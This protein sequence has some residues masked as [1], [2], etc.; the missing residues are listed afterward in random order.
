MVTDKYYSRSKLMRLLSFIVVFFMI[1]TSAIVFNMSEVNAAPSQALKITSIKWSKTSVD[2]TLR[3][4][5]ALT[6]KLNVKVKNTYKKSNRIKVVI[7]N[8]N[9][10]KKLTAYTNKKG[11]KVEFS[12]TNAKKDIG[13]WKVISVS[14]ITQTKKTVGTKP[15][16]W[17]NGIWYPSVPLTQVVDKNLK[18]VKPSNNTKVLKVTCAP[19]S[20]TTLSVPGSVAASDTQIKLSATLKTEKGKSIAGETIKFQAVFDTVENGKLAIRSKSAKTNSKGVATVVLSI[21]ASNNRGFKVSAFYNGKSKKYCASSA[22]KNVAR[23]KENT[24]F[25]SGPVWDGRTGTKT[26]QVKLV[27]NGGKNNG[28]PVVGM[29]IDWHFGNADKNNFPEMQFTRLNNKAT[30][31]NAQGVATLTTNVTKWLNYKVVVGV[32]TGRDDPKYNL[33][34]DASYNITRKETIK[35][36]TLDT[37]KLSLTGSGDYDLGTNWFALTNPASKVNMRIY[38]AQGVFIDEKGNPL[39]TAN[40]FVGKHVRTKTTYSVEVSKSGTVQT[41]KTGDA[42]FSDDNFYYTPASNDV[43]VTDVSMSGYA[44]ADRIK[45][46]FQLG[47]FGSDATNPEIRYVPIAGQANIEKVFIK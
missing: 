4:S 39:P 22:Q 41:T 42:K 40:T 45:V 32:G 23:V 26:F 44:D 7:Q 29:P 34:K 10:K 36:Y 46:V 20:K 28:K 25:I 43:I 37:S 17:G 35:Y 8:I 16:Y 3:E 12:L 14:A 6:V 1:V 11:G 5:K 18:T 2:V 13:K 47:D 38:G 21:P 31:T 15:G 27:V 24:K 33:P 9:T 30:T 19:R